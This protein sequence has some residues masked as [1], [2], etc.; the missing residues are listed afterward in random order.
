MTEEQLY[1]EVK[2]FHD[3]FKSAIGVLRYIKSNNIKGEGCITSRCIITNLLKTRFVN[4]YSFY[5][6]GYIS[7]YASPEGIKLLS[8]IFPYFCEVAEMFDED[9]L[10]ESFYSTFKEECNS[11]PNLMGA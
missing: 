9:L 11:S 2:E 4:V 5:Q 6:C 7:F 3:S 1:K 8:S 10:A